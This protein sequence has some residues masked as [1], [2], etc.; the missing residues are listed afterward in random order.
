MIHDHHFEVY[1]SVET[2][3]GNPFAIEI[4]EYEMDD[5]VFDV[6]AERWLPLDEQSP[7]WQHDLDAGKRLNDTLALP[8]RII[9]AYRQWT[10]PNGYDINIMSDIMALLL[11]GGWVQSEDWIADGEYPDDGLVDGV[12]T[13]MLIL[14]GDDDGD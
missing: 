11:K 1:V 8:A 5:K 4:A 2:D 6:Q 10:G 13:S 9:A 14:E 3:T 7:L 12:P